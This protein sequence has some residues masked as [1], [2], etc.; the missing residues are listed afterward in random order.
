[1]S[2]ASSFT[3]R[4]KVIEHFSVAVVIFSA[5]LPETGPEMSVKSGDIFALLSESILLGF[6]TIKTTSGACGDTLTII[7]NIRIRYSLFDTC[8]SFS[9]VCHVCWLYVH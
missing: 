4:R 1:M 2:P 5:D 9:E 6:E 7:T 8:S 3:S